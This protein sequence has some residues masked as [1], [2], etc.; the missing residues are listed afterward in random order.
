MLPFHGMWAL[1][2]VLA[3]LPLKVETRPDEPVKVPLAQIT[4]GAGTVNIATGQTTFPAKVGYVLGAGD[5]LV[6]S[7]DAWVTLALSTN[8]HV[9]RL[10][11]ELTLKVEGLA[12]LKAGKQTRSYK[13][14]LDALVTPKEQEGSLRLAGWHASAMAANVPQGELDDEPNKKSEE[15]PPPQ[16]TTQT[17]PRPPGT[18]G[19]REEQKDSGGDKK[20]KAPAESV[21]RDPTPPTSQ[22]PNT[23]PSPP[24]PAAQP[25]GGSQAAFALDPALTECVGTGLAALGPEV[26][27]A[28]GPSVLVKARRRDGVV[29]V[30]LG[31]GLTTPACVV[32]WVERHQLS[33]AWQSVVVPLK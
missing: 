20:L 27:R 9:V 7:A 16:R 3:G 12:M 15:A 32:A 30:R 23:T 8:D 24:P 4:L 17:K 25:I 31:V 26:K 19:N 18:P 29:Q 10:D 28:L 33:P 22:P 13:E 21:K 2:L 1:A 6:L 5:T 14:Q 11:D